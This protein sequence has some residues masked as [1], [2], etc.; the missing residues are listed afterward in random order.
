MRELDIA[1]GTVTM[2]AVVQNIPWPE[3]KPYLARLIWQMYDSNQDQP[4]FTFRKWFIS[5]TVTVAM[6]RPLLEQWFGPHP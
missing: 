4:V 1:A 5:F 6:I 2:P 3:L